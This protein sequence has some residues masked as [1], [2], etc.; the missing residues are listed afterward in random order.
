M[1]LEEVQE[2]HDQMALMFLSRQHVQMHASSPPSHE[3]AGRERGTAGAGGDGNSFSAAGKD[4]EG[5]VGEGHE[6]RAAGGL[7]RDKSGGANVGYYDVMQA[8][9]LLDAYALQFEGLARCESRSR[10]R[11]T[12]TNTNKNTNRS[13][14]RSRVWR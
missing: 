11:N 1:A 12:N 6:A 8:E 9:V 10:R 13:R 7:E 4:V 2:D 5:A 3:A 14:Y